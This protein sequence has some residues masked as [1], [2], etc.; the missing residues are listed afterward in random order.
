MNLADW[1][2]SVREQKYGQQSTREFSKQELMRMLEEKD[3]K[4]AAYE[5]LMKSKNR[6]HKIQILI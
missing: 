6:K 4:S 2:E 3:E 1:V 5:M